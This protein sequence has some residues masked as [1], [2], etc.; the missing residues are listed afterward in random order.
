MKILLVEPAKAPLSL[1][2]E[3]VYL[4]E[5][6]ALEYVAAGVVGDHDVRIHDQ[7]LDPDVQGAFEEFAPD[8]VGLTAYTVHA[9]VVRR[10]CEQIK[11]WNPEVLTVVGGHHATVALADF[12]ARCID[13]VVRGEGVFAFREIVRRF[14]R[15][16]GFDGIPGVAPAQ[17]PA[18]VAP[19]NPGAVDLDALPRPAR[20]LTAAYRKEYYAEYMKPLASIRTSKGCPFRCS[21][22]ALWKLTG[23]RYLKRQPEQIVAE[24]A[25]IDEE[26][27]FFADDE[28]LVD[29]ERMK[30]LARLIQEAGLRKRFFLYGRSDTIARHPDLLARWR[31]VGLERIFVGFEF[32]RDEDLRYVDKRST[33]KDN[34]A[35]ARILNDL[36]IDMYASFIIRPEFTREDFAAMRRYCRTLD[37]CFASFAVL[38]PLP[39]TDLYEAVKDRLLTHDPRYFDFI[40]TLLPTTLPLRDFYREYYRLYTR[41]IPFLKALSFLAKYRLRDL[42]SLLSITWRWYRDL[43]NAWKDYDGTA[44]RS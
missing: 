10:L 37:L 28:S 8:V 25:T 27:V 1:G 4:Y 7:R 39:G 26:C 38:T 17:E 33:V 24:L 40:H 5:P 22:C 9:D 42:P 15:R 41:A 18:P 20:S 2:G 6:L 34:E 14:E 35:A 11:G 21:F 43:R 13:V 44:A 32:F 30:T 19:A 3:D 29:A 36:G 12:D 31:E 16:E 23:G